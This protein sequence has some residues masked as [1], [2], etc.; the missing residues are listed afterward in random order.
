M[1]Y[2][3]YVI[4]NEEEAASSSG[5]DFDTQSAL[6]E[7][8]QSLG[9]GSKES[10][11][12]D[13]TDTGVNDEQETTSTEP[14]GSTTNAA[15]TQNEEKQGEQPAADATAAD[16]A[17]APVSW[18]PEVA[19]KF[20]TLEP[21][22]QA[23]ILRREQDIFKGIEQ[24]KTAADY[25]KNVYQVLQP[26]QEEVARRGIDPM[27]YLRGVLEADKLI[28]NADPAQKIEYFKQLAA[29]YGVSIDT[30]LF[31]NEDQTVQQ[32]REEINQLKSNFTRQSEQAERAKLEQI[33]AEVNAFAA[34]PKNVHFNSIQNEIAGL[35]S[36]GVCKTLQEAYEK[37]VWA[38]PITRQA[39]LDRIQKDK[40]AA[41]KK[42]QQ[43]KLE[44]VK[45]RTSA[46]VVSSDRKPGNTAKPKTLDETLAETYDKI[47]SS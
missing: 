39:E 40:E 7:I 29:T 4:M 18:K 43:K 9:F 12:S 14:E 23:E 41:S 26:Y 22:V 25:G 13:N 5:G 45:K 42:E 10:D 36:S 37:A 47:H 19:A 17:K 3:K 1:F 16:I 34:D 44:E 8:S 20:N 21:D 2:R 35:I 28:T 27:N 31:G 6:D 24:Y 15:N 11:T 30:E 38:N 32:L 46:N 33:T